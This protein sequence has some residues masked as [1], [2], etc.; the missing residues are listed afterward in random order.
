MLYPLP[1]L[2]VCQVI[3]QLNAKYKQK[4]WDK[5]DVITQIWAMPIFGK[6]LSLDGQILMGN[7]DWCRSGPL[8]FCVT[9]HPYGQI[10][11]L[12]LD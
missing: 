12:L 1:H 3:P 6:Y 4:D 8:H 2:D 11:K 5:A 10:K 9:V 7:R